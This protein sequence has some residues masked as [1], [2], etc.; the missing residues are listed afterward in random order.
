MKGRV[1]IMAKKRKYRRRPNKSGTVV[2]LSGNRR[3]PFMAKITTGYDVITGNQIQ[4]PIG[5]FE[6][7][8]EALDA[9]SIYSLTQNKN[10]NS[11]TLKELG[12]NTFDEIM[13]IQNKSL[14]NFGQIYD[15]IFDKDLCN[16][17][18]QSQGAYNS[19]F[20]RLKV[21]HHRNISDINLFDMQNQLDL[22]STEVQEKTLLNMKSICVRVFEYAV[23]HQYIERN[24]DFTSYLT[25]KSNKTTN[26]HRKHIPF[27]IDEV[28]LLF[29]DYSIESKCVLVYIF[30]G[31]RPIELINFK[32]EN[33]YL[34]V[35]STDN[36][37]ELKIDYIIA[38]SKTDAGKNRII[39]IHH[40]IKPFIKEV[41]NELGK[42]KAPIQVRNKIFMPLM[43]KL[44][45]EHI[46]YDTRHTFATLAKLSNI[47]EFSRK[48][49]MGHKSVNITDD[50][51][52]HSI[53][54]K[55]Y[56]EM[57]KISLNI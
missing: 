18:K 27:S 54:N 42:Y 53:K 11:N 31:C 48:R 10:L 35:L 39:P 57:N 43:K 50:V 3:K 30:T 2:K 13:K 5:Y 40:L 47:D 45:L 37:N 6:T 16:L 7:R 51:Y 46:P 14:P 9:L 12:G 26:T 41:V 21:L 20:K 38:G 49:I 22:A 56:I 34:D 8:Q 1:F 52:T 44:K 55:L 17:S 33:L 36:G 4:K 23:I 29:D 24:S 25:C 32:K 15:I 19:A 28:K